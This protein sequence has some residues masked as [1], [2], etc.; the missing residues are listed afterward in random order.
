MFFL[1]Q[2]NTIVKAPLLSKKCFQNFRLHIIGK[3]IVKGNDVFIFHIAGDMIADRH[4]NDDTSIL[5]Q[6]FWTVRFVISFQ[7]VL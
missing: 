4:L 7:G 2:L 5:L 1:P 3:G 6:R